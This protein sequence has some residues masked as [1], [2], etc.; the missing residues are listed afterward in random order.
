MGDNRMTGPKSS[1]QVRQKSFDAHPAFDAK[2]AGQFLQTKTC[3]FWQRGRCKRGKTCTY[4][5]SE[6]AV[7]EMPNLTKTSLCREFMSTGSCANAE[8]FF[9]HGMHELRATDVF[10]KT[11]MCSW[12]QAGQCLPGQDCRFAHDESELREKQAPALANAVPVVGQRL[13]SRASDKC[14]IQE[15]VEEINWEQAS[16]SPAIFGRTLPH[17]VQNALAQQHC[18]WV[19]WPVAQGIEASSPMGAA[20][21][22]LF[23]NMET[24]PAFSL[25][26]LLKSAM[27]DVYED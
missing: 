11:S 13:R 23:P 27:P 3:K 15:P 8:C 24:D 5:H 20:G 16:T 6:K 12:F 7:N 26:E 4:A 14:R 2:F 17:E 22:Y 9:A 19:Q 21:P 10:F 25:P 18:V 1:L